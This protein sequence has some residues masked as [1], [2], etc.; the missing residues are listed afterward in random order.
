MSKIDDLIE[1]TKPKYVK[2]REEKEAAQMK[3]EEIRNT[4]H[5][6]FL[7]VCTIVENARKR[8][9]ANQIPLSFEFNNRNFFSL[10]QSGKKDFTC[11]YD[12]ESNRICFDSEAG[13]DTIIFN[14]VFNGPRLE[15]ARGE[16]GRP[17]LNLD[18]LIAKHLEHLAKQ[19]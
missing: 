9:V 15:S 6:T 3:D 1:K 14:R 5:S 11:N 17:Q 4:I 8:L 13:P 12:A 18:A 7:E 16:A 2:D 10:K 19:S